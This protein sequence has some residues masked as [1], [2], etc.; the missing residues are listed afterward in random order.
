MA[1]R[2]PRFFVL[3]I[4]AVSLVSRVSRTTE[5]RV[6]RIEFDERPG[7]SSPTR[8]TSTAGS[9]S[10]P[11][12]ARQGTRRS[13]RRRSAPA[14]D[15][16]SV[17]GTADV[18]FL[19]IEIIDPSGF[20]EVLRGPRGRGR[21]AP[22]AARQKPGRT[23]RHR[24]H[25]AGPARQPPGS[26]RTHISNGRRAT[27]WG[28]SCATCCSGSGDTAPVVREIIRENEPDPRAGPESTSD[29]TGHKSGQGRRERSRRAKVPDAGYAVSMLIRA[30]MVRRLRTARGRWI[31]RWV[32]AFP[33][34]PRFVARIKHGLRRVG[35]A[36]SPS[37]PAQAIVAGFLGAI[38]TGTVLLML[39]VAK[40]GR[41]E[42]PSWTP[43]SPPRRPSA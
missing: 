19:E 16:N 34:V 22:G 13:T 11:T 35:R 8:W 27:R 3:G 43:C 20:S 18:I 36:D 40:Q 32:R 12:A 15:M 9:T 30:R 37:T 42:P 14:R 7:A 1:R 2:S 17:P 33:V 26:G 38:A 10:S 24:R 39:P 21:R 28:T 4:I 5:L 23:Q 25:P 6:E 41:A 31:A 29:D